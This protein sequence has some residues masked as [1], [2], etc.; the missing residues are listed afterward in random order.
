MSIL[1]Y[2]GI[3]YSNDGTEKVKDILAAEEMLKVVL[4]GE[5]F[6]ITMRSPGSEEELIR[7][8]LFTEDIYKDRQEDPRIKIKERNNLGYPTLIEVRVNKKKLRSR[9]L[10][11]RNLL[12]VSSCGI[13][14]KTELEMPKRSRTANLPGRQAGYKLQTLSPKEQLSPRTLEQMF[15][16]MRKKQ[17]TF[18]LS[19]GSHASAA[20]TL[21]G[22]M[23][24]MQEDIGRHNAVDKVIGS[25]LLKRKLGQAQVLLVSGRISYEIVSKCF[26]GGMAFLAAVSAPSSLAVDFSKELGITLMAFCRDGKFT[27]Y[28]EA[29]RVAARQTSH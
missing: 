12:S 7:G 6:T 27:V 24:A 4:N 1:R 5:P 11:S 9:Y 25:L 10:N 2:T 23:L 26:M 19:G 17:K 8:L 29:Q 16:R 15:I 18:D 13:C 3:K 28:S 14:G 21:D 20:F 22:K